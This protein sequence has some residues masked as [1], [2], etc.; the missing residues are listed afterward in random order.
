MADQD[1]TLRKEDFENTAFRNGDGAQDK[2]PMHAFVHEHLLSILKPFADHV[3]ELE[4]QVRALRDEQLAQSV[5]VGTVTAAQQKLEDTS[6]TL[7]AKVEEVKGNMARNHADVT[8]MIQ[9]FSQASQE[10]QEKLCKH[11]DEEILDVRSKLQP[12]CLQ[13]EDTQSRVTALETKA[14]VAADQLKSDAMHLQHLQEACDLNKFCFHGLSDRLEVTKTQG[15]ATQSQL[16]RLKTVESC[17]H[18]EAMDTLS[19]LAR[20]LDHTDIKVKHNH[21]DITRTASALGVRLDASEEGLNRVTEAIAALDANMQATLMQYDAQANEESKHMS[22]LE[23]LAHHVHRIREE[24][25]DLA[26]R[27]H[28]EATDG[29]CKVNAAVDVTKDK[30]EQHDG[31]LQTLDDRVGAAE[32]SLDEAHGRCG[33]LD[34]SVEDLGARMRAAE[35]D[36]RELNYSRDQMIVDIDELQDA[37]QKAKN[38]LRLSEDAIQALQGDVRNQANSLTRAED[39]LANTISRLDLAHEYWNGFSRGL[40]DTEQLVAEGKS[41]MPAQKEVQRPRTLPSLPFTPLNSSRPHSI[42]IAGNRPES[43]MEGGQKPPRPASSQT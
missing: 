2:N 6:H 12:L 37:S 33:V 41:G 13:H 40:Q 17:H 31:Q 24:L 26:A 35:D 21:E 36:L 9:V 11:I 14:Q 16:E 20:R 30:L 8:Q 39:E 4:K 10:R 1:W 7:K 43:S 42:G 22:A 32:V 34:R 18:Q 25:L 5:T 19:R 15:E 29:I 38:R 28:A 23:R 3:R 27:N